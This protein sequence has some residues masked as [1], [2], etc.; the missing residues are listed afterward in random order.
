MYKRFRK[1][2]AAAMAASLL[3]SAS[4]AAVTAETVPEVETM[5][6]DTVQ[7]KKGQ[8]EPSSEQASETAAQEK[9]APTE[10]QTQA[11]TE[12]QTQAPTESQTQAPT[13]SQ[14][15]APTEAQTQ[16]PTESQTQAPT[17]SQ[18]QAPT[19]AQTQAPTESQTQAPTESQTQAP[20]ESQTQAP[21]EAQTQEETSRKDKKD[22]KKEKETEPSRRKNDGSKFS[23]ADITSGLSGA[24]DYLLAA[25]TVEGPESVLE[26]QDI[27]RDSEG[28]A[29][30]SSLEG[31]S[32]KLANAQSG[33]EVGVINIYADKDGKLDLFQ[34]EKKFENHSIDVSKKYYVVN[35]IAASADQALSFS[36]YELMSAGAPVTYEAGQPGDILYNFAAL[37]AD[38]FAAYQG[39]VTLANGA[40]LQG[41]YLA[42][43][44]D[45]RLQSDLAG[46]VYADSIQVSEEADELTHIAFA[47]A[48]TPETQSEAETEAVTE[49]QSEMETEVATEAQSEI[50]T[51]TATEAQSET[52][53]ETETA[54][55]AQSETEPETEAVTEA[56]SETEPETEAVT[57]AQSETET[58]TET[59]TEAQSE[60]ETETVTEAQSESATEPQSEEL[61]D[62]Y[63]YFGDSPVYYSTQGAQLEI[64]L[65]DA[66]GA[67]LTGGQ[68]TVKAAED[69]LNEDGTVH[70]AKNTEVVPATDAF[71]QAVN[72]GAS[73]QVN[74]IYYL[75]VSGLPGQGDYL[76]VPRI[77]LTVNEEGAVAFSP[78]SVVE[79]SGNTGTIRLHRSDK[80]Q[81]GTAVLT[82]VKADASGAETTAPITDAV[83]VVRDKAGKT[84]RDAAGNPYYIHYAGMPV[85]LSGLSAGVYTLSQLSAEAGYVITKDLSFEIKTDA[86]T[87]VKVK[88]LPVSTGGRTLSVSAKALYNGVL[89]TADKQVRQEYY[90]AVFEDKAGTKRVSEVTEVP[91]LPDQQESGV[92]TFKDY[93]RVSG[94]AAA[95]SAYYILAVNE[96]GEV[97]TSAQ[98]TPLFDALEIK[99]AD[100]QAVFLYDHK[101]GEFPSGS[102][103][104]MAD[105]ELTKQVKNADD[106]ALA[107]SEVFYARLY[108][109][110]ERTAP[111]A[112]ITFTMNEKSTVTVKTSL[113][114]SAAEAVYYLSETDQNGAVIDPEAPSYPYAIECTPSDEVT[115]SCEQEGTTGIQ[116]VTKATITNRIKSS[117]VALHIVDSKDRPLSGVRLIVKDKNGKQITANGQKIYVSGKEDLKLSGLK[118]GETYLLSE[119]SA[120]KGYAPVADVEFT[121]E[122]GKTT[123]VTMKHKT[124]PE[125]DGYKL[126][127][128]KQVYAGSHQVY[129]RRKTTSYVA[130]FA[131]EA[132]TRK[133]SDVHTV[134]MSGLSG[135]T[136][137]KNLEHNGVYYIAQTNEYGI[138]VSKKSCTTSYTDNGKIK[139]SSKEHSVTIRDTY[140]ALPSGYCYTA[141]LT[142]TK[143]VAD[144]S[145]QPAN[146][147]GTFYAG[148]FD[149]PE[150][151]GSPKKVVP[152]SLQN[153][154]SA[155]KKVRILLSGDK[156]VTYYIA[157]VDKNGKLQTSSEQFQYDISVDT[158]QVK[159]AKSESKQV[160]ITNQQVSKKDAKVTLYLTKRVY[161]GETPKKVT[162]TFYAGLFK[163]DQF[164]QLYTKPIPLQLKDQSELT[165]KLSLNLGT[166]KDTTIYVAEVDKDGNVIQPAAQ[167]AFGYEIRMINS[168]AA[169]T[170]DRREVQTVLLNS[171]YGTSTPDGWDN[172]FQGGGNNF[173]DWGAISGN[174]EASSSTAATTGDDTPIGLYTALLAASLILITAVIY[175]KK[176]RKVHE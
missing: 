80:A 105:V 173:G 66:Q 48:R 145:G 43:E 8:G 164:T 89:L 62:L 9:E 158:P 96:C 72:V 36:G 81:N 168:T 176:K 29:I 111:V 117:E 83:F 17:E 52:E 121:P 38:G 123:V 75:E 41:T 160:T 11:P 55:E 82:A 51:E 33:S 143:Q 61:L 148:I 112:D 107:T 20:T 159:L 113:K 142:L 90:L 74:G 95:P 161:E 103:Y 47:T 132:R 68:I 3:L 40:G 169:F 109:D 50:E 4:T 28:T 69:I 167:E 139:M 125:G 71:A 99:A 86:Q 137:F 127:V 7:R 97:L 114:V 19:E 85:V 58:E 172:I 122:A 165:L 5:Q 163:D 30:V 120:P 21:T 25:E 67:A 100:T 70:T 141:L 98:G 42:P 124:A 129:A 91:F 149:N 32:K 79:M 92:V 78:D 115:I 94:S 134:T 147:T 44:A 88:N 108:K 84:V 102:F 104:Y 60:T 27:A 110:K 65:A 151:S 56:Q 23:S 15:Q 157:E 130:L 12:S 45:V 59:V 77:Y 116:K 24:L 35:I 162:E 63:E 101:K 136:V 156:A 133:V 131:D 1:I 138:P 10:S 54:T 119:I 26:R 87:Q 170:K 22:K 153:T 73:L 57:E 155:S 166:T 175:K 16:A 76:A 174:G 31:F 128:K 144:E 106:S 152:L 13:E 2:A 53:P 135:T 146:V 93:D 49:T 171:V 140:D 34:L 37:E 46:A 154:S 6:E 64:R 126:T 118:A 14:T 150:F 39:T 18:T